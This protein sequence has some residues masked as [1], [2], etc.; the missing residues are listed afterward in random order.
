MLVR[1]LLALVL[2]FTPG[3]TLR[4]VNGTGAAEVGSAALL[5]PGGRIISPEELTG[6][7]GAM[8]TLPVPGFMLATGTLSYR[9]VNGPLLFS[10]NPESITGEGIAYRD[11]VSGYARVY[12][13][14]ANAELQPKYFLTWLINRGDEPVTVR[15]LREAFGGPGVDYGFIGQ[16]VLQDYFGPQTERTIVI[17]AGERELLDPKAARRAARQYG[18]VHGIYD[19][20]VDGTVE[21]AVVAASVQ[22][23]PDTLPD[24]APKEPVGFGRGIFAVTERYV[25][26]TVGDV[27]SGILVSAGNE[28][29]PWILGRDAVFGQETYLAGNY[30]VVYHI[31]LTVDVTSPKKVRFFMAPGF[32]GG[33]PMAPSIRITGGEHG[34][35]GAEEGGLVVRVPH[36]GDLYMT[37][38]DQAA[39]LGEIL[40][41]PGDPR[42]LRLDFIPPGGSCLPA[43]LLAW[44]VPA[45]GSGIQ[46]GIRG[47]AEALQPWEPVSDFFDP[48]DAK[49]GYWSWSQTPPQFKDGH[50]VWEWTAYGN[51]FAG[52]LDGRDYAIEVRAEFVEP[53]TFHLFLRSDR[54]W[55]G[56]DAYV[57]PRSGL[58][59]IRRLNG[60]W[61]DTDVLGTAPLFGRVQVGE[62]FVLRAEVRGNRLAL[63]LD[64]ELVLEAEDPDHT[65][66]AG[67]AGF[68]VG[69]TLMRLDYGKLEP[70]AATLP[71]GGGGNAAEGSAFE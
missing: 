14:H 56:Y 68:R 17:P 35:F 30:G 42:T 71:G 32:S 33:C 53:G 9:D 70:L 13:Y 51:A 20:A 49:T 67:R 62:P 23:D 24:F 19:I 65:Y 5:Q 39:F 52:P 63:Y 38:A 69:Y 36:D 37:R 16:S 1:L 34:S 6:N 15:V 60:T 18:L 28:T 7:I 22:R 57:D 64:G 44:P 50:A 12:V 10:D 29:D 26:A 45:D 41:E 4:A 40:V 8:V 21:V 11:E 58:A 66:P 3:F 46:P 2:V 31:D 27:P 59:H 55:R 61:D 48:F 54:L 47:L 43:A 25:N